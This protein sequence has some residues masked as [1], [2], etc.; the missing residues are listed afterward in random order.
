[1]PWCMYGMMSLL[2]MAR[3]DMH[4]LYIYLCMDVCMYVRKHGSRAVA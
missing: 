2:A 3:V 4:K 1:M